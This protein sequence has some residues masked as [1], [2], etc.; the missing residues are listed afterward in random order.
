MKK[1]NINSNEKFKTIGEAFDE[2]QQF[3]KIKD[4]SEHTIVFYE[5]GYKVF[6]EFYSR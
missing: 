5:R 1:I 3:N 2:F 6:T 4:L